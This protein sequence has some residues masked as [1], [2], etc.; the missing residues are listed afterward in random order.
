VVASVEGALLLCRAGETIA[1][2]HDVESSL[3]ALADA[4]RT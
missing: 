2:L 3:L 4:L 1:P